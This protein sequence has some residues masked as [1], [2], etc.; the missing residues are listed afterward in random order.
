ML[1]PGAVYH[2]GSDE[3]S[4]AGLNG[5]DSPVC[6]NGLNNKSEGWF[7]DGAFDVNFGNGAA[8]THVPVIDSIEE[9]QSVTDEWLKDYNSERPHDSLGRVPPRTFL[10]RPEQPL[11]SSYQ[12]ST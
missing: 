11:E 5:P 7:V 9:V 10:P 2:S 4:G 1:V 3:L 12:L 6:I 8:N